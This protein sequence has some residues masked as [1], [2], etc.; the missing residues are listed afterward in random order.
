[1]VYEVACVTAVQVTLIVDDVVGAAH[2]ALT[3]PGAV[4]SA[5]AC[6]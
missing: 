1:M 6:D 4:G 3:P 5:W 2:A